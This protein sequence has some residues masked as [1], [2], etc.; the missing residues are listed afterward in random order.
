MNDLGQTREEGEE[1][2]RNFSIGIEEDRANYLAVERK[3]LGTW[4]EIRACAR[5]SRG[6]IFDAVRIIK[7]R[8]LPDRREWRLFD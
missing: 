2:K 8:I 6:I 5:V 3:S 4:P 7:S 1:E